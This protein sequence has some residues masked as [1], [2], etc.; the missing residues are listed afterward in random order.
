M[1]NKKKHCITLSPVA[2]ERANE[3]S[4]IVFQNKKPNL[5]KYLQ[6][7]ILKEEKNVIRNRYI[8]SSLRVGK[9]RRVNRKK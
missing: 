9:V 2:S 6:F 8:F 5:S 7:L 1:E 4:K 3:Y